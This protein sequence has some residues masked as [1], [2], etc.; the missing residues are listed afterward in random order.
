[1]NIK[2]N[3]IQILLI[4]V[5]VLFLFVMLILPL[6]VVLIKAISDGW[7]VYAAALSDEYT[8]KALSLTMQATIV[9]V[10]VNTAFGLF[11]ANFINRYSCVIFV[12]YVDF[13]TGCGVN[14]S[15]Q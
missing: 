13:A 15:D 3:G 12:R 10:V 9:A 7:A 11:A 4:A 5:A 2:K 1:L 8:I 6:A 14:K